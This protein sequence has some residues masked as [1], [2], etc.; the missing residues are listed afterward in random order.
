VN[1]N[2]FFF[3]IKNKYESITIQKLPYYFF[4]QKLVDMSIE[5]YIKS[6]PIL[7]KNVFLLSL[8]F[9]DFFVLNNFFNFQYIREELDTKWLI[10]EISTDGLDLKLYKY[11]NFVNRGYYLICN[12]TNHLKIIL[13]EK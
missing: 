9:G 13:K 12:I 1:K 5:I 11:P 8:Q 4:N 6:N 2:N 10:Y 3:L 7:Y